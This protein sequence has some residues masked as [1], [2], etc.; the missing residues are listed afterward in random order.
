MAY[1]ILRIQKT[2]KHSVASKNHHN[3]RL[4]NTANADD[5]RK[6]DNQVL[7]GCGN[8]KVDLKKRIDET[9]ATV[10]NKETVVLQELVLTASKEYFLDSKN[11]FNKEKVEAWTKKQEEYLQEKFGKNCVNAVLHLDEET[12]HIHAFVT[13]I[14]YNEKK[15]RNEFNNK[16]YFLSDYKR[17]QD[18]YYTHN[19]PLGLERGKEAEIT[20]ER[21][22]PL[23]DYN[24]ENARVHKNMDEKIKQN[25]AKNKVK[26]LDHETERK[27]FMEVD[28]KYSTREVNTILEKQNSDLLKLNSELV[29]QTELLQAENGSLKYKMQNMQN[30]SKERQKDIRNLNSK[31]NEL[32]QKMNYIMKME[33]SW[34][35]VLD[36]KEFRDYKEKQNNQKRP[37]IN[38][39]K[40]VEEIRQKN[41]ATKPKF[42]N[43]QNFDAIASKS[44]LK[45][46]LD[47][48]QKKTSQFD[49]SRKQKL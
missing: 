38:P 21:N 11:E 30:E 44:D 15:N 36:S 4:G 45:S 17:A 35:K 28:K 13:P 5:N 32:N 46:R 48:D 10:R 9:E 34:M 39:P 25:K 24:R 49:V 14:V 2:K 20:G 1:A 7:I 26:P 18:E 31:C 42:Q 37:S 19:K 47:E 8:L 22:L 43:N 33:P 27:F 6:Q 40:P 29:K 23:R 12:P 3:M 16:N 41:K